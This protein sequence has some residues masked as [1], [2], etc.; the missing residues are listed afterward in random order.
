MQIIHLTPRIGSSVAL[1]AETLVSGS[2]ASELRK[3]LAERGVLTFPEIELSDEQ[4][5]A[6]AATLGA[7]VPQGEKGIFKVT[8]DK[9]END[10][11]DYLLG[12]FNWHIDGSMDDVPVRASLLNALRLSPTGGDTEFANT[13]AA[14]DDMPPSEQ[15]SLEALRVVH[16][17]QAVQLLVY[18]HPTPEQVE[19][20]SRYKP[21]VHPLVWKH[22]SGRKSLLIGS[23]A[24]H[25]EGMPEQEG[26]AL[27]ARLEAWATQ[28]QFVYRHTWNLGDLLIWDNTG[29]MHRVTPYALDSGRMMHRTTLVG[30]ERV[31]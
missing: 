20:W 18:P 15:R 23:T 21:K 28:P 5:V 10:R 4:Q 22:Q 2:A 24:S 9:R 13:Y 31:A 25:I 27:L 17:I 1:D 3:L 29:T 7:I 19:S 11:A 26:R 12:A 14:Y 8:L 6:F 30:E 16:T